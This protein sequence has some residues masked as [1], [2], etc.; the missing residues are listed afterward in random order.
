MKRRVVITGMGTVNPIGN[1]VK[2]SIANLNSV[3]RICNL[4]PGLDCGSCGAPSCRA[5]AEDI[6]RGEASD[7]DCIHIFKEYFNFLSLKLSNLS[8]TTISTPNDASNTVLDLEKSINQYFDSV[9]DK[10]YM[11]SDDPEHNKDNT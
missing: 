7:K 6:V 5:L 11:Q 8:Q 10:E 3:E 1:S 9:D 2:E 4:F